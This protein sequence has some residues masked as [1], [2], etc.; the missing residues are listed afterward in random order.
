MFAVREAHNSTQQELT[1]F[2]QKSTVLFFRVGD[3]LACNVLPLWVA[4]QY[5]MPKVA[6]AACSAD[7]AHMVGMQQLML[8]KPDVAYKMMLTMVPK[9]SK[10]RKQGDT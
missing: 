1:A 6:N 10:K 5:K 4:S 8:D 9:A 7:V 2:E 3:L